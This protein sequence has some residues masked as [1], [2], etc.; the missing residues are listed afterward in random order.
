M[1]WSHFR[2]CA[3]AVLLGTAVAGA[4]PIRYVDTEAV[5]ANNGQTWQDAYVN[6]QSALTEAA[7]AG[8]AI[9]QIWVADG[10]Y[11]PS[12]AG[13]QT[14]RFQMVPGVSLY[15]GFDGGETLLSQ[16]NSSINETVLSG[17]L[18]NNDDEPAVGSNCCSELPGPNCDNGACAA[19]VCAL[20]SF[21][22]ENRWDAQCALRAV[23]LCGTLCDNRCD[24]SFHV[25]DASGGLATQVIDG[26]TITGGFAFGPTTNDRNGGGAV[27]NSGG[28]R[29]VNC[30]F[31]GN[32]AVALGGAVSTA[33]AS[34][35]F[36]NCRFEANEADIGGA[37]RTGTGGAVTVVR[38]TFAENDGRMGGAVSIDGGAIHRFVSNT[39]FGNTAEQGAGLQVT[40]GTTTIANSVF[41]NNHALTN[42]G[43]LRVIG[44]TG[45]LLANS[46]VADNTASAGGGVRS[47][48]AAV[49]MVNTIVWG[50]SDASGS[51]QT[52]QVS[53]QG[54]T[55]TARA[56]IIEGYSGGLNGSAIAA[57]DPLFVDPTGLDG[58]P[59]TDDDNYSIE[60]TSPAVDA[61]HNAE[62]PT[63]A[64]D[65]DSDGNFSERLPLDRA[66]LRRFVIGPYGPG[67]GIGTAPWWTSAPSSK[68]TATPTAS[69]TRRTSPRARRRT[70]T[71][72]SSPTCAS[73]A[74]IRIATAT[75]TRSWTRAKSR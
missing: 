14:A 63:D 41:H 21:C 71:P 27:I 8:G 72:T 50:N 5:G 9:T 24:N 39:F 26:F 61:G 30:V 10:I 49:T 48:S 12:Q 46:T 38:S 11:K 31:F 19:A 62:V 45:F 52:A 57:A 65:L 33:N 3:A 23:C 59:G 13:S 34:P 53:F 51:G 25:I 6:L 68:T 28:I 16:R 17:D 1:T 69:R 47:S 43:A 55:P 20:D 54:T 67:T 74:P 58:A 66:G 73:S 29:F 36:D 35:Q 70:A 4:Q 56:S 2:A 22:C 32:G 75:T 15:G 44:G 42:G 60:P 40:A 37:L 7:G 64:V 18:G